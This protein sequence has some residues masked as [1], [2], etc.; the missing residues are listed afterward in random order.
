M[1]KKIAWLMVSCLMALSLV[2]ASCAPAVT[3]EEEVVTEEKEEVV[4]EEKEEVVTEE[5]VVEK[6]PEMV[7][8]A[9]GKLVEKP[10]YGGTFIAHLSADTT[11]FDELFYRQTANYS[12]KLTHE[13]L[14]GGDWAKGPAGTGETAWD[15][16]YRLFVKPIV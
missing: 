13:E 1:K 6:K 11:G 8:D 15:P 4:T 7:R 5:V 10:R 3:E 16:G 9:L 2:L 12:H 14:F